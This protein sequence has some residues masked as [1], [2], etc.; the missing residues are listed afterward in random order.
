MC[1]KKNYFMGIS[2]VFSVLTRGTCS[3]GWVAL[4]SFSAPLQ[5]ATQRTLMGILYIQLF[6][7][8]SLLALGGDTRI[9]VSYQEEELELRLPFGSH[10]RLFL[11]EVIRAWSGRSENIVNFCSTFPNLYFLNKPAAI[12]TIDLS[13]Q[14]I[15]IYL[16]PEN[17]YKPYLYHV[18]QLIHSYLF[19]EKP[20]QPVE[21]CPQVTVSGKPQKAYISKEI[22]VHQN[23]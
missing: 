13:H 16:C 6:S 11:S 21:I 4:S 3:C 22:W 12:A 10:S 15:L 20:A 23:I 14:L 18:A 5:Y 2:H 17:E 1:I 7:C 9:R 19:E 8:V